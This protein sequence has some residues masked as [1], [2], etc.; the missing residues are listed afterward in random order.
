MFRFGI[1]LSA[2]LSMMSTQ[3]GVAQ[4]TRAGVLT[5]GRYPGRRAAHTIGRT[6][7]IL[8]LSGLDRSDNMTIG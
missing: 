5:C 6:P 1:G 3:P 4:Q 2:V 8:R 7:A